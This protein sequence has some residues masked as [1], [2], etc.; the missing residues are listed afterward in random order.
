[1]PTQARVGWKKLSQNHA[2]TVDFSSLFMRILKAKHFDILIELYLFNHSYKTI[3]KAKQT[4][5]IW[6]GLIW[7]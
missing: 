3:I 6:N 2:K 4:P 5:V 7:L 1:M